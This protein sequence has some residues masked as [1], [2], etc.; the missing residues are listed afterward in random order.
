MPI[1]LQREIMEIKVCVGEIN[2]KLD[3][4]AEYEKRLRELES[5]KDRIIGVTVAVNI[6]VSA[7]VTYLVKTL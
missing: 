5:Y 1:D 3:I 7:I 4:M 2:V 6:I